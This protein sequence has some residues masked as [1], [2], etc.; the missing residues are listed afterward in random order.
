VEAIVPASVPT[1]SL[2]LYQQ[3]ER[4]ASLLKA[5]EINLMKGYARF[6]RLLL[7]VKL[8]EGWRE[9]G[10]PSLN[11]YMLTLSERY[12]KSTQLLYS[13]ISVAEQLLPACGE[14]G[15]DAMGISK[16]L[17]L[18]RAARRSKKPIPPELIAKA[19]ED[20]TSVAEIRSLAHVAF[21]LGGEMPKGKFI[22]LGGFYADPEEYRTFADA[23][24]ISMRI[25]GITPA[26]PEA[27]QRKK[28]LLFWAQEISG[29][30]AAEAY[31]AP[32]VPSGD[33][34]G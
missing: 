33:S 18:A 11:A 24:K 5:G 4:E 32:E 23:V 21:E 8:N 34:V 16:A 26:M 29:T 13:Y 28:I 2:L 9:A 14:D 25:L 15:L 22:D 7:L 20:G 17:E 10:Q 1:G 27:V 6:A 12:G 19:I 30:Y 3:V 31:G